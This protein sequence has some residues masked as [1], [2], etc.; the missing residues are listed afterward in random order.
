MSRSHRNLRRDRGFTLVE[1]MLVATLAMV[2]MFGAIY[3]ASESFAVVSEGDA[4][5]HTHVQGRRALDRLLKDCRYSAALTVVGAASTGWTLTVDSTSSLDPDIL[6]Y[7]WNPDTGVLTVSDGVLSPDEVITGL[8]SFGISTETND[9]GTGPV[10][11]R[12]K[13]DWTLDVDAGD[14][15][16]GSGSGQSLSL[17]GASWVR[18]NA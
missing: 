13:F 18:V 12:I 10:I 3:S 17:S 14:E 4:R 5:V 15:S 7:A 1:L 6:V 11:T 9:P 16:G 2:L 8:T